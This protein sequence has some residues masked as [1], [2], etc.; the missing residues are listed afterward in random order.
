M[1]L[2]KQTEK[3]VTMLTGVIDSNYQSKIGLLYH[4]TRKENY[5]WS[6]RDPLE[7]FLILARPVIKVKDKL[8]QPNPGRKTYGLEPSGM[9]AFMV[10]PGKGPR[11]SQMLAEDKSNTKA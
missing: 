4:N 7:Y 3:R 6:A 8:Q 1:S 11:P 2:G 10:L 9:K 5:T